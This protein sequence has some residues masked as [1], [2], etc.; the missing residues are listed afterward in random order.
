M[1]D[2]VS[3][4]GRHDFDFFHGRWNSHN[5]KL[6][7]AWDRGCTTWVEFNSSLH[8]QP[9]LGGLGNIEPFSAPA[10]P[11]SGDRVEALT[12]RL[13][14]PQAGTWR[15][16]WIAATGQLDDNPM[17]GRFSGKHGEFFG[18]EIIDGQEVR[19]RWDWENRGP[20]LATWEQRFSYDGGATWS[21]N[22]SVIHTRA[23]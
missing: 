21:L 19:V 6:A 13:F 16:W 8:C 18:I 5:R 20:G 3:T 17:A 12:L 15:I 10:M 22:W 14:D 11:P 9:V 23:D 7:D 1:T 2:D 4:D